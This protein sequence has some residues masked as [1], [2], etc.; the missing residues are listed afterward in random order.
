MPFGLDNKHFEPLLAN[1]LADG[2]IKFVLLN[3]RDDHQDAWGDD[4]SVQ[5]AVG[6]SG[7]PDSLS[8]WAQETLTGFNGFVEYLHT[9]ILLIDPLGKMPTTISGSANFSEA[10]T[11]ANDENMLVI[12][13]DRDVADS[14]FTEYARIFQHFYARWWAKQLA[15]SGADDSHSFLTEDDSWQTPYFNVHSPKSR[16]RQLYSARLAGN[17]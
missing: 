16:L 10:S 2:P 1:N 5:V 17:P 12:V 11:S 7:G 14:Y 6:A 3:K 13:G 9:K 4:H 15:H 8:R